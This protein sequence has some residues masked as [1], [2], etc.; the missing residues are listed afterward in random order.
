MLDQLLGRA[1]GLMG[2]LASNP[3]IAQA[4]LSLLSSRQGT[5]GGTG[6][7]AGLVQAF[8]Q[9]GMGDMVSSWI[10][11]GPNPPVSAGQLHDVLGADVIGQ[12]ASKAGVSPTDA[13]SSLASMLPAL[14]DHLSPNG[15][16]PQAASVE[17]MIGS[18]MGALG[19]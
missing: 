7:L 13:A 14:V 1:P 18:L 17:G 6:G 5:I 2:Q 10:S 3:Q 8:A 11:T 19:R 16:M 12:I 9:K 15:Q 4:A